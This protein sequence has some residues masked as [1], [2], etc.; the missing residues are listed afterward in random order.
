MAYRISDIPTHNAAPGGTRKIEL[1]NPT[2]PQSEW[3]TL[4][5]V[6]SAATAPGSD[7]QILFNDGGASAGASVLTWNKTALRLSLTGTVTNSVVNLAAFQIAQTITNNAANMALIGVRLSTLNGSGSGACGIDLANY[8]FAPSASVAIVR[9]INSNPNIAPPTGVTITDAVGAQLAGTFSDVLGAVT[10]ST[11]LR[12]IT[13]GILGA[14]KPTN[15]HAIR[16]QNQGNSGITNSYGIRIDAQSGSTNPYALTSLGT[17]HGFGTE[18]PNAS[19]IVDMVSTTQGA[20]VPRMTEAQRDAITSPATGLEVYVTG[21]GCKSVYDGAGWASIG[22]VTRRVTSQFD[23]TNDATL[24]DVPGLSVNVAAGKT[25]AFKAVLFVNEDAAVGGCKFAIGGTATA[26]AII[27]EIFQSSGVNHTRVTSL[28]G[29]AGHSGSAA[30]CEF[31]NGTITVN[32]AGTLT[33]QFAENTATAL[34]TASMLVGS[35]FEVQEVA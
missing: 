1:E 27:A 28:G 17:R 21:F 35:T 15:H 11:Y 23:K 30:E 10:N 20:M 8:T 29:S 3:A 33:V 19:A 22:K 32:A 13:P 4:A 2:G 18:T 25:Y 24:A 14:L 7:T 6:F 31:I 12:F 16:I 34:T 5:E 9:S 26:T